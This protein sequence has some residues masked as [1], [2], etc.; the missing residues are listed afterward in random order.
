[1]TN[2]AKMIC[3]VVAALLVSACTNTVDCDVVAIHSLGPPNN[4]TIQLVHQD[5]ALTGS[6]EFNQIAAQVRTRL[7]QLGKGRA[8]GAPPDLVFAISYRAGRASEEMSRL[9]KCYTSYRYLTEDTGSPY[10]RG[11]QCFGEEARVQ[12]Q[13]IHFLELKIYRPVSGDRLGDLTYEGSAHSVTNEASIL[14]MMP[15]LVSALFDD[16]PGKSGEVRQ[17]AVDRE[18]Q[19]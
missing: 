15:Y 12:L 3:M 8:A 1:M 14:A 10:Y 19:Q 7:D 2:T 16:F 4:E 17:V 18:M 13:F 11:L 6:P 9:P 5:E